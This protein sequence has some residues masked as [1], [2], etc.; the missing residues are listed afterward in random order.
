L[1]CLLLLSAV[2][3]SL[4]AQLLPKE[5]LLYLTARWTGER[6]PDGRPKI[7]DALIERAKKIGIEEAWQILNNEG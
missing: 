1:Y 2:P 3:V 7:S 6:F 5:E 4:Q